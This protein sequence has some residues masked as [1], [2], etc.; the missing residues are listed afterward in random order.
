MKLNCLMINYL[1]KHYRKLL[2]LAL[3][4]TLLCNSLNPALG[5]E[6]QPSIA[7]IKFKDN[8]VMLEIAF[9]AE[10]F[11]AEIDSSNLQDTDELEN[12]E[13]YTYFRKMNAAKLVPELFKSQERLLEAITLTAGINQ[14]EVFIDT[15]TVQ[16]AINPELARTTILNLN[17]DLPESTNYIKFS[18]DRKFGPLI[19]RQEAPKSKSDVGLYSAWLE[20]GSESGRIFL[21]YEQTENKLTNFKIVK[22]YI[23]IGIQHIVPK[24]QDHILFIVGLFFFSSQFRSLLIQISVFT[25]AHS[26]TLIL[27]SLAL[28]K[29]SNSIVE[30][31]IALSIAWIGFENIFR[32]R[33]AISRITTIFFFGLLHGLGFASVLDSIGLSDTS[34][35]FSL[36]GFNIGV[37]FG[38]IF[39]LILLTISFSVVGSPAWYISKLRI[40]ISG[41]IIAIGFYWFFQRLNVLTLF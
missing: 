32:P 17:A 33:I 15:I 28:I 23:L 16:E 10:L 12:D 11:L 2:P 41:C 35:I 39:I 14:L 26:I 3:G 5:H 4:I 27:S 21:N 13:K 30:P 20:P 7:T 36:I 31:L 40:P 38:Q 1:P 25:L 8:Q 22:D 18:W 37:E 9:N 19:I 6:V 29:V 24:G 34:F